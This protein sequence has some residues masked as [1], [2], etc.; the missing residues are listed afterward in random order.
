MGIRSRWMAVTLCWLLLIPAASAASRPSVVFLSPDDS[1]FWTMVAEVMTEAAADLEMDLEVLFDRG[2]D[3]LTYQQLAEQV[4]E[5]EVRPDYLMFMAKEN[6]TAEMLTLASDEGVKVFTFNTD[7]PAQARELLGMP[8]ESLPNWIGHLVPDNVV[9]GRQLAVALADEAAKLG[10]TQQD[11]APDTI[12]LSGTRDSSA[13]KDRNLGLMQAAQDHRIALRQLS[14]ADWSREVAGD[15][16]RVLLQRYPEVTLVWS[17][18]DGMAV[19]AIAAARDVER[20]P[21]KDVVI[22]GFDWEP[23]ALEAI[24]RGEL[25]V[26]LGRHFLGGALALIQLHDYHAGVDFAQG[27]ST[28]ALK[29]RFEAATQSNVDRIERVMDPES[30]QRVDFRQFSRALNQDLADQAPSADQQMDALVSA[31]AET[32]AAAR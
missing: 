18:S 20:Q 15:K 10:L 23:E 7:I 22:G 21:G 24:R 2:R 6:V 9:A 25:T 19:G 17:A 28:A 16:T 5:R 11:T 8:R 31:L 26:S 3:R 1:V 12:A 30:W 32:R 4:L 14:F 27:P 29:Y 13:A